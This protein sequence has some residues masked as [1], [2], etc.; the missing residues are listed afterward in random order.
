M[1]YERDDVTFNSQFSIDM[2]DALPHTNAFSP[3]AAWYLRF[4]LYAQGAPG[5]ALAARKT[6]HKRK[7]QYRCERSHLR[8]RVTTN[9]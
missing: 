1:T 3:A 7:V 5:F 6:K 4:Y 9:G 8:Y 2:S